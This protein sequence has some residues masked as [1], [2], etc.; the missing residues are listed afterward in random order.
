[1]R[2]HRDGVRNLIKL[3]LSVDL[4]NAL[5]RFLRVNR[6]IIGFE[7]HADKEHIKVT[8]NRCSKYVGNK[9]I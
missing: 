2:K 8:Q 3:I 1:M 4:G 5:Q 7:R 6:F 9:N